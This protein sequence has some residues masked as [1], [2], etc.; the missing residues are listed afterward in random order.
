M[1]QH[2]RCSA[3][4]MGEVLHVVGRCFQTHWKE[5]QRSARL[6]MI[7]PAFCQAG[8]FQHVQ[9][10]L[11]DDILFYL[12][13]LFF[14]S[15][16][17]SLT[18]CRMR[19]WSKKKQKHWFK[20]SGQNITVARKNGLILIS[21]IFLFIQNGSQVKSDQRGKFYIN[22]IFLKKMD[23][24]LRFINIYIYICLFF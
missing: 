12:F 3:L 13:C 4:S 24:V 5:L 8:R 1:Q 6:K 15:F 10:C 17:V 23:F 19:R 7:E 14:F 22:W 16:F 21:W 2:L 20:N 9:S 11:C 18:V